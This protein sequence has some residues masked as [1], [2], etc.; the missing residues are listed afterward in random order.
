[1]WQTLK[2][3]SVFISINFWHAKCCRA[4]IK[5]QQNRNET[6]SNDTNWASKENKMALENMASI[7]VH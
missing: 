4:G 1:M 6:E 2:A 7:S 5:N 3:F